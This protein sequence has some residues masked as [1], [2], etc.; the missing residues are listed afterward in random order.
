MLLNKKSGGAFD[1]HNNN[2]FIKPHGLKN[3]IQPP[4]KEQ[5]ELI[6]QKISSY[7]SAENRR[8]VS[9]VIITLTVTTGLILLANQAIMLF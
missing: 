2:S 5:M 7:A 3:K 6:S 8:L 1:I 9:T 4:G